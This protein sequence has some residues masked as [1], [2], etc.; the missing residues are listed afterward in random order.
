LH[1][2]KHAPDQENVS[3]LIAHGERGGTTRFGDGYD[4]RL[5][6]LEADLAIVTG[7]CRLL[8]PD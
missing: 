1:A 6:A 4:K 7:H 3:T 2:E 5:R 8:I